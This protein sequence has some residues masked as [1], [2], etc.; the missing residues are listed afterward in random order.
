MNDLDRRTYMGSSDAA[1]ACGESPFATPLDVYLAKRGEPKELDTFPIRFGNFNEMFVLS[2][3]TRETGIELTDFQKHYRHP[4][5]D[6]IGATIDARTAESTSAIV[7]AKTTSLHYDDLPDH[8]RIQVQEQLACAGLELAFVPVLMRGRDLKIFEV[9]ADDQLQERVLE[10]MARLW[11]RVQQGDPPPA[12]TPSDVKQL[13]PQDDGAKTVA[14]PAMIEATRK[15]RDVKETISSLSD[16]KTLLETAI[17][18]E[19]GK[20]A[21]LTDIEGRVLATWKTTKPTKRFDG[22]ALKAAM[23]EVYEEF[24][25]STDGSRRFVLKGEK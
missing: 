20:H 23:P 9:A 14:D 10:R 17:Q 7:E 13:F 3:F 12:I 19:M 24:T 1:P 8:I 5:Y 21:I 2:E 6:F 22:K 18:A 4:E 16:Q 15:L 11:A 25:T